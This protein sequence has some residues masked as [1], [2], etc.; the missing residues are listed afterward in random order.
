MQD[1]GGSE[2]YLQ[3]CTWKASL[4][5]V[6]WEA[7]YEDDIKVYLTEIDSEHMNTI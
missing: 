3:I 5:D 7:Y 4:K 6:I 2:K 1:C